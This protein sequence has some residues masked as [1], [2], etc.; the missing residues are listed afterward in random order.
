[1]NVSG[2]RSSPRAILVLA[3]WFGLLAG[4]GEVGLR[5]IQDEILNDRIWLSQHYVWMT[6]VALL[7]VFL[8]AAGVLLLGAR[9]LRRE[10]P[11]VFV[12]AV[13]VF[14]SVAGPLLAVGRLHR[15]ALAVVALGIAVQ[16]AR[17]LAS[18]YGRV[19][20]IAA[21]TWPVLAL[22]VLVLAG[23]VFGRDWLRERRAV[24]ALPG[25]PADAPNVLLV[26]L[27]T[28]RALSLGFYGYPLETMPNLA[29]LAEEGVVFDHAWATAPWTLPSHASI[30]T[31]RFA[32]ELATDLVNPMGT[33]FPTLAEHLRD[34]GYITAG[35]AANLLYT[36]RE[37]GVARGFVRYEDYPISIAMAVN[38]ASLPRMTYAAIRR[39]S[40][41]DE[42][43]V[44]KSGEDLTDDFLSWES[45]PR[46]RPF[47]VFMNYFDAHAPYLPPDSLAGRFGPR[48]TGRALH[49]LSNR[50]HWSVAEIDAE[51]AAYDE[52]LLALDQQLGR[53]FEE[54]RERGLLDNTVVVVTS[55]H[56]EQ[57]GEHGLMDHGNSL[58]R[59]LL[60]VPLIVR[61][62]A[63]VPAGRRID[64]PVSLRD[65]AISLADL[66]GQQPSPFPGTSLAELWQGSGA[67]PSL[68][69]SEV[70]EGVRTVP[71]LPLAKGGMKSIVADGYHYIENGDGTPE[72]YAL[73]D[74][75]EERNLSGLPET[76][77]LLDGIRDLLA[78]A[79]P[80][81]GAGRPATRNE[82]A[83]ARQR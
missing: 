71:W 76:R 20:P 58:Y 73:E 78:R 72:L 37:V 8:I 11:A 51:R 82:P 36:T 59:P 60:E 9:L 62:P 64:T 35:F 22:L 31:G 10:L 6:P 61:Y 38:S 34:R 77:S 45:E 18:R 80:E 53:L 39:W 50:E 7:A 17:L 33:T 23:G 1:M 2:T 43:M 21:R 49:D 13:F 42:K 48:R 30:F 54:L 24:A 14:L 44:R 47:F 28:V 26:I 4:L 52:V 27:D 19:L 79:W 32:H 55:D 41:E 81:P 57:F 29:Q 15:F 68:P 83:V 12:I 67:E 56:G 75:A 16:A 25:A 66:S 70:R 65:L 63:R 40:G 46:E 5:F 74:D 3:L 69:L